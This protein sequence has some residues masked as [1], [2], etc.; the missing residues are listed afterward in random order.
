[1]GV[2]D[3]YEGPLLQAAARTA[4][5]LDIFFEDPNLQL[6][7]KLA[8]LEADAVL[9]SKLS[10]TSGTCNVCECPNTKH[11]REKTT[12]WKRSRRGRKGK[13]RTWR[14][15]HNLFRA[16]FSKPSPVPLASAGSRHA[17][18]EQAWCAML[19]ACQLS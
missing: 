15:V 2:I 6:T 17:S 8:G 9:C 7:G 13:F 14:M 4:F 10:W 5:G 19:T 1:M 3:C 16:V 12:F 11:I 18:N